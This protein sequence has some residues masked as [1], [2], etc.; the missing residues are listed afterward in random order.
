MQT[1]KHPNIILMF[2]TFETVYAPLSPSLSLSL[3]K[4]THAPNQTTTP[5]STL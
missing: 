4:P 1:L 3:H 5:L 2:D